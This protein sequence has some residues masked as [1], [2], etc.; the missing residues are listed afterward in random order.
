MPRV[1]CSDR[2]MRAVFGPAVQNSL[3]VK[4]RSGIS[5]P[6]PEAKGKCGV[7]SVRGENGSLSFYS[8]YD[9]C[10]SRFEGGSVVVVLEVQLDT[11]G[12]WFQVNISCPL[13]QNDDPKA[14]LLTGSCRIQ[15][16]LRVPCGPQGIS[17]DACLKL[18][19]CYCRYDTAC[20]YRTDACSLD[21]NFVFSV[22]TTDA[23]PPLSLSSLRVR[24]QPQCIPVAAT[25]DVAIFKFGV[26]ECGAKRVVT[27]NVVS[28]EVEVEALPETQTIFRD[29]PFSLQVQCQYAGS[30]QLQM[31]LLSKDPTKPPPATALGTVK[32]QMRIATD[33]SFTS[34]VPPDQLPLTLPLRTPVH[35]EVSFTEPSPN[36]GLSLHVRDCFAF[37]ASRHSLWTLLLN[38]CPN[39]LDN[40]RSSVFVD[41]VGQSVSRTQV[42]RFD[43]KTFA[44][45][46]P[47]TGLLSAEQ[48][49]F[50]CWV[51]ICIE[52]AE[53]EQQCATP[54]SVSTRMKRVPRSDRVSQ[55]VSC[56]PVLLDQNNSQRERH[57]GDDTTTLNT[58]TVYQVLA[59]YSF[60]VVCLS[61]LFTLLSS[62]WLRA[63]KSC[64]ASRANGEQDVSMEMVTACSM[65]DQE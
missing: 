27:G 24:G 33:S 30:V 36:P 48:L 9:S 31:S 57:H 55:L 63:R 65:T 5:V 61:L 19:C 64:Q 44:F 51:E 56:G 17:Q 21:G 1:I 38:G 29:S 10:Y 25:A 3:R 47:T 16:S 22:R 58:A 59:A 26:T 37:P 60:S 35:V 52:E 6:V 53:C 20:Y 15:K 14:Y 2:S 39:P 54:S 46:D 34:F 42:K 28:Y 43:V 13:Q 40:E 50:Y 4:D 23:R 12:P 18:G 62:V 49:Y 32:V 7:N 41:T 11:G 8:L 45:I